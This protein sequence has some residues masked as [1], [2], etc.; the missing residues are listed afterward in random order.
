[1]TRAPLARRLRR[2]T[3]GVALALFPA[4]LAVEAPID[5]AGD[6]TGDMMYTA[7]T[8]H[9]GALA[10][11]AA[12]LFVSGILMIPAVMAILHQARDRG[13]ALAN[14]GAVLGVL[15][16]LG[17][18]AIAMFYLFALALPGGDQAQMVSYVE[19]VNSSAA[20]AVAF[21]LILC[22]AL[23]V[24][25]LGWAAWRAGLV[26]WWGPVAVTVAVLVAEVLPAGAPALQVGANVL[27]TVV[28]GFLGVRVIRMTDTDWDGVRP[29]A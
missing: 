6:G 20:G 10:L 22:F 7:A 4:L 28:F 13:S 2:Y 9:E 15:G 16:G 29:S 21:P 3:A 27:A 26:G 5:P 23:G 12:L 25:V 17:H 1:V 24:L 14:T 18:V 8:E 19:R 11:S